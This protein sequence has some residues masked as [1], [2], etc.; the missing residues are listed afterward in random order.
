ML[1][2]S[3]ARVVGEV[4]RRRGDFELGIVRKA[5]E[6][7]TTQYFRQRKHCMRSM[8]YLQTRA[9]KGPRRSSQLRRPLPSRFRRPLAERGHVP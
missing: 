8:Q 3:G 1:K 5:R 4:D 6:K 7:R 9:R 2:M